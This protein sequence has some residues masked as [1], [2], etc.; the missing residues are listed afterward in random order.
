[1][2]S[3]R[4]TDDFCFILQ[5]FPKTDAMGTRLLCSAASYVHSVFLLPWLFCFTHYLDSETANKINGERCLWLE[6][7]L[8]PFTV[9]T[10][11]TQLFTLWFPPWFSFICNLTERLTEFSETPLCWVLLQFKV[12][13]FIALFGHRSDYSYMSVLLAFFCFVFLTSFLFLFVWQVIDPVAPRYTA[14][15]S[16]Y[17]VPVSVSDAKEEMKEVAKH[18]KVSV[19]CFDDH[20]AQCSFVSVS[21]CTH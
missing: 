12:A 1:M 16:S 13:S 19:G 6:S 2:L 20:A 11:R 18:P 15:S 7:I 14:L 4:F 3:Y 10:L 5:S 8:F 17:T 9:A 21:S